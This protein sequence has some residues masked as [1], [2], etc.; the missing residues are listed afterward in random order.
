[1]HKQKTDMADDIFVI[2]D[3]GHMPRSNRFITIENGK[4]I[5]EK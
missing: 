3:G 1:M 2:N 5:V 4:K